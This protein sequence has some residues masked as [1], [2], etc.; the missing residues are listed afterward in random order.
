MPSANSE[1]KIENIFIKV[2]SL[3]ENK[4]NVSRDDGEQTGTEV[5]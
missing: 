4:T 1:I 2:I 5:I 3:R